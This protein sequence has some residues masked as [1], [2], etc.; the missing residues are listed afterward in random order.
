M[1][2]YAFLF[3]WT[4]DVKLPQNIQEICKNHLQANTDDIVFLKKSKFFFFL[5]K[6]KSRGTKALANLM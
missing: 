5:L 2:M 4:E 6:T 1:S 3:N